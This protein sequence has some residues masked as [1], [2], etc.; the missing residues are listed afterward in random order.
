MKIYNNGTLPP[1]SSVCFWQR[2]AALSCGDGLS[3]KV[4]DSLVLLLAPAALTCGGPC[5]GV[6]APPCD[7]RDE[8]VSR[9]SAW[10]AYRIVANG[11]WVAVLC[12]VPMPSPGPRPWR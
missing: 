11:C 10:L 5:P 12:P 1:E 7:E 2:S 6:P 8:A 9:K 4:A 3:G